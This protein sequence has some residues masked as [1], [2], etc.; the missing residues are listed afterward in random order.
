MTTAVPPV[1]KII[2][3]ATA[4]VERDEATSVVHHVAPP[5]ILPAEIASTLFALALAATSSST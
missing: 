4:P 2:A 1:Q 3:A 5:F